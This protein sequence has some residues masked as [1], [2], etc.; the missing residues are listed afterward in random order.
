[1]STNHIR[2]IHISV[3]TMLFLYATITHSTNILYSALA[4]A[5]GALVL[6][7]I[8][9]MKERQLGSSFFFIGAAVVGIIAQE[10][11]AIVIILIIVLIANFLNHL[12]E[13]KTA[14]AIE[15]LI[16]LIPQEATLVTAQKEYKTVPMHLVQQGDLVVVKTGKTIPVDGTIVDGNALIN[17]AALTGESIAKYK[18]VHEL[19]FAGTF[20][21]DGS[22]IIRT[23]HLG[24]ETAV[25]KISMLIEQA[26][27]DK[28]PIVS[29]TQKIA[30]YVTIIL[31]AI[32][33]LTWI[34][35]GNLTIVTTLLVFGSPVELTLITPLTMLAGIACA[36]KNGIIVKGGVSLEQL[37]YTDVMVFDKTGTL[38]MGEPKITDVLVFSDHYQAA[39]I[40]QFA[41]IAEKRSGHA[42]ARAIIHKASVMGL[43]I[44]EP[45]TYVSLTGHGIAITYQ[46]DSYYVGNR[47]F[48]EAPEHGNSHIPES[49]AAIQ[50]STVYVAQN[51]VV[52]GALIIADMIRSEAQHAI[53]QLRNNGIT[54]L[55]I[56][57]GDKQAIATQVG[58]ALGITQSRGEVM[59]E[60]KL[61]IIKELQGKKKRVTMVGDGINDALALQQANVGIAMGAMGTEP[62]I[63]AASIVLM[64]DNLSLLVFTYRLARKTITIIKQNIVWGLMFTHGLGM[65]LG[66]L[67]LLNPIQA[68]LFHAVPELIIFI[69]TAR[70]LWFKP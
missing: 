48:I 53:E 56:I 15:H 30:W 23:M 59:P 36:F 29:K 54:E 19:V 32:I 51:G 34:I 20:V 68:A 45:N 18:T 47:H 62:A 28:A 6:D 63:Q 12:I 69:N 16:H 31:I 33:A 7:A 5:M 11:S 38:T 37:A 44:A 13:E 39:D 25:G 41:A 43:V 42:V 58:T 64:S 21:E 4:L 52:I 66:M 10:A 61:A 55:M 27:T 65:I 26:R 46:G 24:T 2:I 14:E 70:I 35:T 8:G 57:S 50:E 17:E 3:V 22:I 67:Q 60:Q 49:A 1:M 9:E 40:V